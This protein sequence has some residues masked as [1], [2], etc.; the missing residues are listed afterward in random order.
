[1]FWNLRWIITLIIVIAAM[2]VAIYGRPD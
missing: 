1:M 2:A